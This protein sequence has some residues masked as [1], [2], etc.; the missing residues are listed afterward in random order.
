MILTPTNF[1]HPLTDGLPPLKSK[2]EL[3]DLYNL[4]TLG[5]LSAKQQLIQNL[6]LVA[7]RGVGTILA[8]YPGY[9][10]DL[11][12]MVGEAALTVVTL[13]NEIAAGRRQIDSGKLANYV[14]VTVI[15]R[16]NEMLAHNT[17]IYVSD[18]TQ[19]R[20]W[21]Q[22]RENPIKMSD[23][24][25][26]GIVASNTESDFEVREALEAIISTPIERR[27]IDLRESGYT[28]RRIGEL[29]GLNQQTVNVLRFNMFQR[30]LEVTS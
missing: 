13:V 2:S 8:I 18:R 16:V 6:L 22:G 14:A 7:K 3:I 21:W 28:D 17:V 12:D 23:E 27:I 15:H 26:E 5:D 1:Y 25:I 10:K 20:M 24:L 29:L 11:D 30:Y 19:R 9:Q 4:T